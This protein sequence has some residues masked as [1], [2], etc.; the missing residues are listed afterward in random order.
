[1]KAAVSRL[2]FAPKTDEMQ[3]TDIATGHFVFQPVSGKPVSYENLNRAIENAG[4]EIERAEIM[5]SG[6]PTDGHLKTPEGQ[7]F[8]LEMSDQHESAQKTLA[9]MSPGEEVTVRGAWEAAEEVEV[10]RVAEVE[11]AGAR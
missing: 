5:V 9:G 2:E 8:R 3:V 1:M 7:L 6:V 10:I 11:Q 4:Y